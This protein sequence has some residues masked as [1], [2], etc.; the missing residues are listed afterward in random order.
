M[1]RK[2]FVREWL[3]ESNT[4]P[5]DRVVLVERIVHGLHDVLWEGAVASGCLQLDTLG[6]R[7]EFRGWIKA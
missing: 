1:R 4:E 5:I 6:I 3:A 2:G 7:R